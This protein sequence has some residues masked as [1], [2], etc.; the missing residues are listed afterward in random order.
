MGQEGIG[1]LLST[2]G[3]DA[4][5]LAF[6]SAKEFK[7]E[8]LAAGTARIFLGVSVEC[9]QCHNHPFSDWKR[10]QFWGFAAFYSGIQS[11]RLMDF[12]LPGKEVPDKRELTIPGTET[13]VQARFLDNT[14]PAWKPQRGQPDVGL[15][16]RHRPGRARR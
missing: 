16:P 6:Y 5:P 2:G 7:A 4:S 9:A 8:S 13:V 1:A 15:L 3:G 12:L 10:E 14:V 11:T